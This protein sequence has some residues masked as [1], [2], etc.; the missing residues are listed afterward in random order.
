MRH[1]HQPRTHHAH[2]H[3]HHEPANV[4]MLDR[5]LAN[6]APLDGSPDWL[7]RSRELCSSSE[8]HELARSLVLVLHTA[9]HA[10]ADPLT[11][12]DAPA[13]LRCGGRLLA[14]VTLLE[15]ESPFRAQGLALAWLLLE[16]PESP[17]FRA[18]A[19]RTL[20]RALDEI[21]AAL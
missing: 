1:S 20:E 14:L 10:L 11:R 9:Q 5:A 8:R 17:L 2:P 4:R 3:E 13:I 7:L 21:T 12:L 19:G 15:S 6:G 18:D 16:E